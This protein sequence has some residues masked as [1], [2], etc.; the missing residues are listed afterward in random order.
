MVSS[1]LLIVVFIRGS[2]THLV[3]QETI[4]S[5]NRQDMN[6]RASETGKVLS[7]YLR[8]ELL[9]GVA[10]YLLRSCDL[11]C[12][13]PVPIFKGN[14]LL[15]FCI[16]FTKAVCTCRV[17]GESWWSHAELRGVLSSKEFPWL[18][19]AEE[20]L[21]FLVEQVFLLLGRSG[22]CIVQMNSAH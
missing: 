15:A 13:V 8:W 7:K 18:A 3:M 19:L 9:V 14:D 21:I 17:R 2:V 6:S 20:L 22:G 1:H 16:N 5:S 12:S 10:A 11:V 4:M